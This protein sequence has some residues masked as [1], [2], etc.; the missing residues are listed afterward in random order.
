MV[1]IDNVRH[2]VTVARTIKGTDHNMFAGDGAKRIAR[3]W[4]VPPVENFPRS[5]REFSQRARINYSHSESIHV[6]MPC[7]ADTRYSHINEAKTRS[8]PQKAILSPQR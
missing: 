3:G 5:S 8:R 1:G 2:P 7:L 6:S 4:L